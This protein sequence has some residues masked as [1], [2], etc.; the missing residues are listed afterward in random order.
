MADAGLFD[1]VPP[2]Q[3][4]SATSR[5]AAHE[6]KPTAA[7]LRVI[8]L[9]RIREAGDHGCTDEEAYLHLIRTGMVPPTT[10]DSTLRARRVELWNAGYVRDS[11]TRRRTTSNR[12]AVVWT[13]TGEGNGGKKDE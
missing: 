12:L 4:H 5:D 7:S 9:N 11:G 8:V 13:A 6:A 2:Y 10:K 1:R 3:R